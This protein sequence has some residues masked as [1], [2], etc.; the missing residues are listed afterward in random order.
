MQLCVMSREGGDQIEMALITHQ[1]R[2]QQVGVDWVSKGKVS[3]VVIP[4]R[5][6][7]KRYKRA[8]ARRTRVL[9]DGKLERGNIKAGQ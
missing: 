2:A 7:Q 5:R 3:N 6:Y 9:N 8:M 4:S 1:Q